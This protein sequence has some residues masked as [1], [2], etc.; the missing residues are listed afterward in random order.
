MNKGHQKNKSSKR[1]LIILGVALLA[2]TFLLKDFIMDLEWVRNR[3]AQCS[4]SV[5]KVKFTDLDEMD[6]W[7]VN[8]AQWSTDTKEALGRPVSIPSYKHKSVLPSTNTT[9]FTDVITNIISQRPG[10]PEP[11]KLIGTSRKA[12]EIWGAIDAEGKSYTNGATIKGPSLEFIIRRIRHSE[13]WC[14]WEWQMAK[15]TELP[16]LQAI[17]RYCNP[18]SVQV[19]GVKKMLVQ[20]DQFRHQGLTYTILEINPDSVTVTVSDANGLPAARLICFIF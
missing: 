14:S 2:A 12:D 4:V 3:Q 19:F 6:K 17:K 11:P 8:M 20:G 9:G 7:A 16:T 1:N 18:P 13:I 10:L 5:E 15:S